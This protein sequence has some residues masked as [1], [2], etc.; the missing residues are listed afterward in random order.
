MKFWHGR[1][2]YKEGLLIQEEASLRVQAS[3]QPEIHGFEFDPVITLGRRA[4]VEQDLCFDKAILE[5]KGFSVFHVD[6]GGEAT[7]HNP[8]QL[9]IYPIVHLRALDLGVR[10]F[11]ESLQIST[12]E[13]L[14]A[15]GVNAGL[16]QGCPGIYTSKGKI[17]FVGVRI[18]NSVSTHGL[19]LNVS[20]NLE[21]FHNIR[22]CGILRPQLDRLQDWP[23]NASNKELHLRWSELFLKRLLLDQEQRSGLTHE[24]FPAR[25]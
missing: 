11:V 14:K 13:L 5:Q 2:S 9:V 19:A 3:G 23:V 8:G 21:D 6:R 4:S 12:V 15:Q 17:G 24:P 16:I 1:V 20:N 7:L 18:Q 25:S 22:S 10:E